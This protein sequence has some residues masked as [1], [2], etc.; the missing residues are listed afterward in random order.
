MNQAIVF[1][2]TAALKILGSTAMPHQVNVEVWKQVI[3]VT[4][5]GSRPK[6]VS[7]KAFYR[8][9]VDSRKERSHEVTLHQQTS[10]EWIANTEGSKEYHNVKVQG[11]SLSCDCYDFVNQK[12]N[13]SGACCKHGYRLLFELGFDSLRDFENR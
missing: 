1:T 8:E 5:K 2:K 11:K 3:V 10:T 6:F 13:M 7:K 9:F 4:A 12:K